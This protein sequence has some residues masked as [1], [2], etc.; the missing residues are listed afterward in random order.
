VQSVISLTF[1]PL[2]FGIQPAHCSRTYKNEN[3]QEKADSAADLNNS[4]PE[5][6]LSDVYNLIPPLQRTLVPCYRE[7]PILKGSENAILH[8]ALQDALIS[9]IYFWNRTLHVSDSFSVH[10]QESSTVH[11]AIGVRHT[12]YADCWLAS[13]QHMTYTYC[14]VYSTRLLMMDRETVRNM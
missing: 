10:H 4:E 13:S 7:Q 5:I 2:L 9:Q 14:C 11:T 12:G 3:S 8:F 6:C 1:G